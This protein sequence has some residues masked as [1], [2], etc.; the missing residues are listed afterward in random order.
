M[1]RESGG[2]AYVRA[3]NS[4]R[5]DVAVYTPLAGP[6]YGSG[7]SHATGG[8]ETQ[9]VYLARALADCG[10]RV[11]HIVFDAEAAGEHD[12]V[13]VLPIP[14]DYSHGGI[15]R[16]R[17]MLRAL[18]TADARVYIQR[19]A[20]FET[21]VIAGYARATGRRFV[22]SSSSEADFAKDPLVAERAGASLDEWPT[23]LQYLVG[24]RLAH[25]VVV[26]TEAQR[27]LA[28]RERGVDARVIRSFC[29]P[30]ALVPVE[31]EAFLWIGG[32][33]GVKNPLAF[34]ELAE[35]VPDASFRMVTSARGEAWARLADEV[36]LRAEA[37]PNLE[38]LP[39]LPRDEL[40]PLYARS[41]AIVNT[42][43]FEGFPNTF[44]EGWARG[45]PAL[46]LCVDPDGVI[47]S[48]GLG[49]VCNGSARCLEEAARRLW[50]TRNDIQP[51]RMRAYVERIHH[52]KVIAPQWASL[53]EELMR[54]GARV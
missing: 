1:S 11:S 9:S 31:R 16:R 45:T 52:P 3:G 50:H 38:L 27:S 35:R 2:R 4:T 25:A 30:A 42:S 44:L 29:E 6:L 32:L 18:R 54:P 46:S 20:G 33:T 53:V 49:T 14:A 47:E 19:S 48:H 5:A 26:Q 15:V 12:G 41:V 37:A 51:E 22:F 40:L 23:R 43:W 10:F 39:A 17:A 28:R 7:S 8:A 21:G 36:R 13:R 24:L 34:V